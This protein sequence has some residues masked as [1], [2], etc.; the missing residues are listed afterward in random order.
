VS[1]RARARAAAL[2]LVALCACAKPA[3]VEDAAQVCPASVSDGQ[4]QMGTVLEIHLCAP[5]RAEGEALLGELFAE[6]AR[7]ERIFSRFDVKSDLS[8]LTRAAGHGPLKVAPELVELATRSSELTAGTRGVFDVSVGPIVVLWV[9]AARSGTLPDA[10]TL[11]A[12]RTRVGPQV[13]RAD[14]AAGTV[15][16]VVEGASLDFGGIAKGYT[17]D[18]LAAMLR[19]RGVSRA[20][21]SFGQSSITALGRPAGWDGWGVL[22][23]DA[24]GGFAGTAQL[25]NQSLSVSGSLGQYAEIGGKRYGHV[26]NPRSGAPLERARVAM[27]VASDGTRAEAFSKALLILGEKDGIALLESIPDAQGMLIDE[28]GATW[29]TSGWTKTVDYSAEFPEPAH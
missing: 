3:P 16:L 20:L 27:T 4:Y 11:A 9:E 17:L 18:R 12:A 7:L 28:S 15:E 14:A 2:A 1:F 10:A 26:I 6:V 8:K 29:Q 22:L 13:V 5:T 21:L 25:A 23:G 24:S 19:A